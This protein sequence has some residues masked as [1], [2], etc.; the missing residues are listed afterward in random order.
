M[1]KEQ[2]EEEEERCRDIN[3]PY[4]LWLYGDQS[5]PSREAIRHWEQRAQKPEYLPTPKSRFVK[6]FFFLTRKSIMC[7]VW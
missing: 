6:I 2:G 5:Y 1:A 4:N 3:C 7:S